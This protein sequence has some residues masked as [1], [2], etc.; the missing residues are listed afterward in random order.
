MPGA[1]APVIFGAPPPA[2]VKLLVAGASGLVGHGVCIAAGGGVVGTYNSRPVRAPCRTVKADLLEP[3]S[4]RALLAAESP[5]A[6]IN[7]A[8]I[9]DV[10]YCESRPDEAMRANAWAAGALAEACSDA[11]ARLVHVSTDYVFDG[12]KGSPYTEEDA[13]GP[14]NAY[15]A[16][17]AEGE[18]RVLKRGHAV[19]RTGVVYGPAAPRGHPGFVD[20]VLRSL[21]GGERLRI[22]DDQMVTPTPVGALAAALLAA[23]RSGRGG[24]FHVAGASCESRYSLAAKAAAAFGY[25]PGMITPVPSSSIRLSARRPAYACLDCSKA[26]RE[27]GVRI[28]GAA[29]GLRAMREAVAGGGAR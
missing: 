8:G 10:D 25:E 1:I 26:A 13:P 29:D 9:G 17:K 6:V 3:G 12:A 11:G 22:V 15:G 18:R 19:V 16:S 20:W 4:A 23:A 14:L 24:L 5:D 7:A 21:G 2:G 28:P 27:L